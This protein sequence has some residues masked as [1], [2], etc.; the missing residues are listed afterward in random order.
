M[1]ELLQNLSS[2]AWWLTAVVAGIAVDLAAHYLVRPLIDSRRSRTSTR[3]EQQVGE[4]VAAI[5]PS[6]HKQV[7]YAISAMR[8]WLFGNFT[9][10]LG[11]AGITLSLVFDSALPPDSTRILVVIVGVASAL[12]IIAGY[13]MMRLANRMQEALRRLHPDIHW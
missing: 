9:I 8:A 3:R 11:I 13:Q 10:I 4:L 6:E 5:K 12:L 2:P 7:L 1:A